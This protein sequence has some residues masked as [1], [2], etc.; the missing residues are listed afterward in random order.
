MPRFKVFEEKRMADMPVKKRK[1][2]KEYE[3]GS[4]FEDGEL[5]AKSTGF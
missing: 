4:F 5:K 2:Q 1:I 3:D